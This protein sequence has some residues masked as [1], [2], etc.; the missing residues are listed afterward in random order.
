MQKR[1]FDLPLWPFLTFFPF[2]TQ[3][4]PREGEDEDEN[5][6][7]WAN[8]CEQMRTDANK[9]EQMRTNAKWC[10]VMRT[11]CTQLLRRSSYNKSWFVISCVVGIIHSSKKL[12]RLLLDGQWSLVTWSTDHIIVKRHLNFPEWSQIMCDHC[13]HELQVTNGA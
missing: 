3:S 8:E 2:L 7:T 11:E 12:V 6:A 9:Y 13:L 4:F 10:E 1:T 5:K